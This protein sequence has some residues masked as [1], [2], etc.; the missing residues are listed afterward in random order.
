M[1]AATN[2]WANSP[3][4]DPK[5]AFRFKVTMGTDLGMLWFAKKVN[6]PTFTLTEAKH[7]F[8][9]H[10]FYWPSRTEWNE[11]TMTLVDPT[12]PDMASTLSE[13]I[14][15]GKWALPSSPTATL[16]SPSKKA[17]KDAIG[18]VQIILIDEEG[19]EKEKWT[20]MNAWIKEIEF[21][22]LDYS[23]DD[24]TEITVKLRY[25]WA[26]LEAAGETYFSTTA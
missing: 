23:S 14:K 21:S 22:E 15:V 8:M 17:M 1:A 10:S 13:F 16:T 3:T 20:L 12:E 5:R 7:D 6:R 9:N 11:V 25:D 18:S 26:Q 19:A 24:L 2:F 4:S